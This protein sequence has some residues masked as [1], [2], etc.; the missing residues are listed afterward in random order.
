MDQDASCY[1]FTHHFLC[2]NFS[3]VHFD[4]IFVFATNKNNTPQEFWQQIGQTRN[5]HTDEVYFYLQEQNVTLSCPTPETLIQAHIEDH[6]LIDDFR[7]CKMI[8]WHIVD[9]R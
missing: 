2:I 1:C 4:C 5:N 8:V 9:G 3:A 6:K 7:G